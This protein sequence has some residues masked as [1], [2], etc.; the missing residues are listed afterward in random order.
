[1]EG[2]LTYR[3]KWRIVK[4]YLSEWRSVSI[5][6]PMILGLFKCYKW[7]KIKYMKWYFCVC[8]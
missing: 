4:R 7:Y 2:E 3:M 8:S 5:K 1:M 6:I